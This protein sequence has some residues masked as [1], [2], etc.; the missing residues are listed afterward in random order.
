M[1]FLENI[2][3]REQEK[4]RASAWSQAVGQLS[5]FVRHYL[6]QAERGSGLFMTADL[7]RVGDLL[8]DRLT[9]FLD[10]ETITA[11]P[12]P[13]SDPRAGEGGCVEVQSTNGVAYYLFWDGVTP[14][15]PEHWNIVRLDERVRIDRVISDEAGIAREGMESRCQPLSERSL[16]QALGDLFGLAGHR[17][18]PG[19]EPAPVS[20]P[21][22]RVVAFTLVDKRSRIR[23]S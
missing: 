14:S 21:P 7:L 20:G 11:T 23:A 4:R 15:G 17:L 6:R 22:R 18:P 9:V 2:K 10:G 5:R 1:S 13:L 8:L 3:R 16:D 12:L 19:N